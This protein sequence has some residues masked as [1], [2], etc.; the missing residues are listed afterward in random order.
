MQ[1]RSHEILAS[2][3]PTRLIEAIAYEL[4][5]EIPSP[6]AVADQV[7]RYALEA[8]ARAI[9]PERMIVSLKAIVADAAPD[10]G[11]RERAEFLSGLLP[12]ALEGYFLDGWMQRT[13]APV[14]AVT[15]LRRTSESPH[16]A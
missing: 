15:P 14:R 10:T 8:C 9:P 5:R 12:F 2:P 3:P 1:L 7:R 16:T 6:E 13:G 11:P 4:A